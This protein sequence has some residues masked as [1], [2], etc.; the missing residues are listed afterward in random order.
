MTRSTEL[1]SERLLL[2]RWRDEDRAP[3]AALNA[4]PEVMKHFPDVMTREESDAQLDRFDAAIE[5]RGFGFWALEVAD[6]GR[7][8]GVTGLSVPRFTAHF[9]PTVEIGWR[10]GR[11]AWGRGYASEAA[12][13][14]LDFAFA[15]LELPEV[16]AF[17]TVDND[18]SRAVMRRIGMT[19]DP[20]D[21]FDHPYLAEDHPQRRHV[22]Y[23]ITAPDHLGPA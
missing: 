3:Y 23:R 6:T 11:D 17:T 7:F 13:R 10:L 21:D 4:D 22:L 2:R 15:D 16:V 18:R 1:R 20:A 9:T 12:R 14:C 8:V 19:H 5:E